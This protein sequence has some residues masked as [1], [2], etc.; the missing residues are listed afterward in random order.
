MRAANLV[1]PRRFGGSLEQRREEWASK[2]ERG[3]LAKMVAILN[4]I[5]LGA[6]PVRLKNIVDATGLPWATA[7]RLVTEMAALG[8]VEQTV[9][10]EYRFGVQFLGRGLAMLA[11]PIL[12]GLREQTGESARVWVRR[13]DCQL[14]VA[15]AESRRELRT[16]LPIGT[17]IPLPRGSPGRILSEEPAVLRQLEEIG[18]VE[19][20]NDRVQ[21]SG[22][23]SAP[24][25]IDGRIVA[26]LCISGPLEGRVISYG[27]Q[28]GELAIVSAARL[29]TGLGS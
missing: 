20:R 23:V 24:V 25:R 6:V 10:K 5:D 1:Y 16:H 12:E 4:V 9:D 14:C 15:S 18:W 3:V 7:Y 13:S 17:M 27:K 29:G 21:G 22:G 8:L 19:V 2:R 28:F 26:A 11:Q